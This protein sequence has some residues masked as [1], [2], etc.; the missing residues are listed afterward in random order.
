MSVR[1][2]VRG[3]SEVTAK[4]PP[5][6][7]PY[8]EFL[9]PRV[10]LSADLIGMEI[11]GPLEV[12]TGGCTVQVDL[13]GENEQ[14]PQSDP[15]LILSYLAPTEE[16]RGITDVP[17]GAYPVESG[18][19][20]ADVFPCAEDQPGGAIATPFASKGAPL[21]F[22]EGSSCLTAV[23]QQGATP[24]GEGMLIEARGPP[25]STATALSGMSLADPALGKATVGEGTSS[26]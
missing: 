8:L 10:L 5:L 13:D 17:M 9:E 7:S 20:Q 16:Q 25:A 21:Q 14:L 6:V 11:L 2:Q 1:R 19:S 3:R 4:V 23:D 26:S 12:S 22:Q 15:S 18:A 24:I